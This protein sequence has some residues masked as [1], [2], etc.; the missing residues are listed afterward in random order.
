MATYFKLVNHDDLE[1]EVS[2]M[3]S[4]QFSM[5]QPTPSCPVENM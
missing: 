2:G 5:S 1:S 3:S 4:L